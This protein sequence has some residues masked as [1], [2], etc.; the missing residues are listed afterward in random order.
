MID[1]TSAKKIA[2]DFIVHK[3]GTSQEPLFASFVTASEQRERFFRLARPHEV[4]IAREL[5][6]SARDHWSFVFATVLKDGLQ[7]DGPTF[8]RVDHETGQ[9]SFDSDL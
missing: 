1:E 2:M 4:E 5:A 3:H 6:A 9:P 7:M 8:V